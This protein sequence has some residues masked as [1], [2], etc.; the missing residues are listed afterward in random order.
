MVT[1]QDKY[2]I[3]VDSSNDSDA[4]NTTTRKENLKFLLTKH[5]ADCGSLKE[6]AQR[7]GIKAGTLS[8]Y[9]N[10]ESFPDVGNLAKIAE[11]LN[12]SLRGLEAELDNPHIYK[13]VQ[14]KGDSVI[15]S[16]NELR[17]EQFFPMLLQ[18]PPEEKIALARHLL[19]AAL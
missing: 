2:V 16:I 1:S 6:L 12:L 10:G 5:R 8:T 19:N 14:I 4:M 13:E 18:L 3:V 15:Y 9:I 17:A 11:Y 7:M